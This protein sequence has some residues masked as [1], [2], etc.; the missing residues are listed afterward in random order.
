MSTQPLKN[1]NLLLNQRVQVYRNLR[2]RLFSVLDR[3]TRRLVAYKDTL[4]LSDVEFKVYKSGQERVRRDKQKNVHAYVIGNYVG[5][6]V[7]DS[8]FD[9]LVY[10]N[11]Y[12]TDTFITLDSK[13]PIYKADKCYLINGMCYIDKFS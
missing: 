1:P 3:K 13:N 5:S 12:L 2:K 6:Q 11:P 4:I 10:Y 9:I 7:E 8:E